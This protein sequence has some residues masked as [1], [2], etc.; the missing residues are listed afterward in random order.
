MNSHI[1]DLIPPGT[2]A[3]TTAAMQKLAQDVVQACIVQIMLESKYH[4]DREQWEHVDTL[5]HAIQR[6]KQH[7]GVA[8]GT[9]D[10]V[11]QQPQ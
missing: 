2:D 6:L 4:W 11:D 7:W 8:A 10:T 9:P 5:H 3:A 1:A